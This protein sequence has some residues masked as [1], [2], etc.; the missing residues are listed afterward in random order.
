M[1]AAGQDML[2]VAQPENIA[3]LLNIRG[4]DV[5]HTPFAL[6]FGLLNKNGSFDWFIRKSRVDATVRAHIGSGLRLHRQGDMLAKLKALKGKTVAFDPSNTPAWFAEQM[7]DANLVRVTDLCALP[8]AAKH[9]AEIKASIAAHEMD[10]AALCNFLAWLDKNAGK[11]EL[12]EICAAKQAEACRAASGKLLDLSFDTISGTGPNGAIVHYRVTE[13]TNRPIKPGDLY[14]IDSGGQ[15]QQGTTDVTRTF[16][17]RAAKPP[18]VLSMPLPAFCAAISRSPWLIFRPAQTVCNWI[19][20]R[21]RRFGKSGSISTMARAMASA[22]IFPCMK[23][24]SA[25]QKVA[26]WRC[27]KA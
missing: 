9:K 25:F 6:S 26:Q 10:G 16:W 13:K 11:G 17:S 14:L 18:A 3:W 5:P 2:L 22:A 7:L 8:K 24:R 23:G 27:K 12:T 19:R 1:K 20:W 4:A 21:A 15:Y